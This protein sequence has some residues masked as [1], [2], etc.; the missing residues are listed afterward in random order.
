[1]PAL[2]DPILNTERIPHII[3]DDRIEGRAGEIRECGAGASAL[4][5]PPGGGGA[6]VGGG[7]VAGAVEEGVV[8]GLVE[9]C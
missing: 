5:G 3:A 8:H 7:G 4:G 1:M 2:H 9:A 6:V